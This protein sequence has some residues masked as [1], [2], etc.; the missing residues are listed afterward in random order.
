MRPGI[1]RPGVLVIGAGVSGLSTALVLARRGWKVSVLA[2]GFG[3]ETVTTVAGAVW[4]WPPSVCGRHHGQSVLARSAGWAMT[5]YRRFAQLA[6]NPRSGVS[7]RPAVFYFR[8]RV[9]DHPGELEKMLQIEQHLPGFIHDPTLI[10]AHGVNPDAGVVDAYSYLAPVVDTDR[11][12]DWLGQ[13]VRTAGVTITRRSLRGALAD[14]E[15]QLRAEFSAELIVNC[16]GLGA[17]KLAGDTTMDPHRGALLR[18]LNDGTA[19]PRITTVLAVA[20]DSSAAAQDM[21]FIVP[22]GEDR[23]LIGGLVEAGRWDTGLTTD[24]RVIRDMLARAVQFLPVLGKA[25]PDL[26]DPLRV[27]LRPF[28]TGGARVEAQPE[29]GI[30]HNYGHGGAGI[31]LSWGCAEQAADTADAIVAGGSGGETP[32]P[33]EAIACAP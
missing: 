6:A 13:Q 21:I 20:N 31:T 22:R 33:A 2:D 16:A 12:L 11:Y 30:V 1:D 17:L 23:L 7:L 19:M 28:R 29:T 18:V 9:D 32:R 24:D 4:E 8:H 14:Q 15:Q 26:T 27:G 10:A 3:A 25:Q 5:S